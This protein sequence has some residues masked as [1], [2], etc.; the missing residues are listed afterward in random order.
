MNRASALVLG[1]LFCSLALMIQTSLAQNN[2]EATSIPPTA[3][4]AI[5]SVASA[6]RTKIIRM[7]RDRFLLSCFQ[8]PTVDQ[9]P[10]EREWSGSWTRYH[11]ASFS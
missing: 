6:W 8:N 2:R 1:S 9:S 3:T 10:L 11:H 5:P 4:A 7:H